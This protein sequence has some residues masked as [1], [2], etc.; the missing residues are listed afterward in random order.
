MK[1]LQKNIK[2]LLTT[3]RKFKKLKNNPI[4]KEYLAIERLRNKEREVVRE[5]MISTKTFSNDF[6]NR[7][8]VLLLERK[9][10]TV[11]DGYTIKVE[12]LK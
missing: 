2:T 12:G 5:T 1:Q 10:Y 6:N 8:R 9:G 11:K 4:V 7:I 3:E